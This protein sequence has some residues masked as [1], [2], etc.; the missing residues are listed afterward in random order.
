[1]SK[2]RNVFYVMLLLCIWAGVV[3]AADESGA[4]QPATTEKYQ[5]VRNQVELLENQP[6]GKKAPEVLEQARKSIATAQ[7]GLKSGSDKTTSEY[8]EM[9]ALQ[10]V[11]A[12]ALAEERDAAAAT[13]NARKLLVS[14]EN[15]LTSIL[16]GKGDK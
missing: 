13:E 4:V 16:S 11:L 8:A 10:V 6:G 3:H 7:A 9:A 15:R 5:K 12:G 1:M 2:I 14:H